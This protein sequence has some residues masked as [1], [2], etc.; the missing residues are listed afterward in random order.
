MNSLRIRL[1]LALLLLVV[2][3]CGV[4]ASITYRRVLAETSDLFDYELRQMALSL[5]M[6]VSLAPRISVPPDQGDV[7]FVV[8]IWDAF[9]RRTYLSR[10]GLPVINETVLGYADLTLGGQRWRTFGLQTADGVVQIAQPASVRERLAR[11]AALRVAVP[12]ILLLPIM[13]FAVAW[14]VGRGLRPLQRLTAEVK[15]RDVRSLASLDD[16]HLPTEL[17][18]LARELNRLL[19]RLRDAF[20]LQRAFVAD[21]AHELRS[22]LTAVRLHLQLLDRAP[23]QAARDQARV[24]LGSAVEREIHL[25]EQLLALARSE[26]KEA[27]ERPIVNLAATAAQGVVDTNPLAQTRR[28]ELSLE[29]DPD[30]PLRGDAESLRILVRN[31]VDNAVRYTPQQGVVQVR[32]QTGA[33][34][35]RLEVTDNGPGIAPPER[36]RVFDRFYRGAGAT[37]PGSGL[38][39]AIV[40]AVARQHD[41]RITL[42]DAPR[43]GLRVEVQF[44]A[45]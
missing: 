1:L 2:S 42:S 32:C 13:I 28:I 25:V 37:E 11:R 27:D 45:P 9:G 22:P 5:R 3:I 12:L 7:D 8:Q 18:P 6:Q 30:V 43:G 20:E 4:A 38:G 35:P 31:L 44:L 26:P 41:A 14:I 17:A 29:A 24:Q 39:L 36:A 33:D 16:R 23:D 10:P 40:E 34:G 15:E 19:G 21:A